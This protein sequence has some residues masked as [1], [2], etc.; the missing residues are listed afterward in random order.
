MNILPHGLLFAKLHLY[1][2]SINA[3]EMI[4]SY[5]TNRKQRVKINDVRRSRQY[6]VR[7]VPQGSQT[8]PVFLIFSLMTSFILLKLY[9]RQLIMQMIAVL[10]KLTLILML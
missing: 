4:R 1:G 6:T 3:C 9:V 5:L 8:G 10:Q 7:G 2:L